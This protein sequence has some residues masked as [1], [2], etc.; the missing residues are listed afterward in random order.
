VLLAVCIEEPH[1]EKLYGHPFPGDECNIEYWNGGYP[2]LYFRGPFLLFLRNAPEQG[3][4]FILRLVNFATRCSVEAE[5]NWLE[6]QG[7]RGKK[8]DGTIFII[9]GQ[10]RKWLG[11]HRTFQWH[12]SWPH[13][14]HI[15]TC[16]LMALEKWLYEQIDQEIDIQPYLSRILA[17]SESMAFAGILLDIGKKNPGLF[18]GVLKPLLSVWEL[19]DLDSQIVVQKGTYEPGLLAWG[20]Q[21]GSLIDLAKEWYGLPHRT[22]FFQRL[23][24]RIM[25]STENFRPFFAELRADWNKQLDEEGQPNDLRLLIERFNP[26]NYTLTPA[27]NGVSQAEF[28]WPEEI[29]RENEPSLRHSQEQMQLMNLPWQ[30]RDIL[31][32]DIPLSPKQIPYLWEKLQ[33]LDNSPPTV[34]EESGYQILSI[35]DVMCGGIAVLLTFHRE[36]LI[37]EPGRMAWCRRKLEDVTR[38]PPKWLRFDSEDSIGRRHWDAFIAECGVI[39]LA[40]NS[41]DHFAR[42]LVATGVA[43]FHY[44]TTTLTMS[45]ASRYRDKLGDDFDRLQ[46]LAVQW[47]ALN[48]LKNAKHHLTDTDKLDWNKKYNELLKSFVDSSLSTKRPSLQEINATTLAEVEKLRIQEFPELGTGARDSHKKYKGSREVLHSNR[49]GLDLAIITHAFAWIAIKSATSPAERLKWLALIKELLD[50]SLASVPVIE[51]PAHQKIDS[52]PNDFDNWI[53]EQIAGAI[54]CMTSAENPD[55]LWKPI[56][57]LGTPAHYWVERFLSRWFTRG[58]FVVNSQE[59]FLDLWIEMIRYALNHPLWN[60]EKNRSHD[61]D[62]I[63]CELPGLETGFSIIGDNEKFTSV[64]ERMADVYA[65]AAERWFVMPRV[66][67]NFARFVSQH[68]TRQLLLPGIYW[69]ADATRSFREYHWRENGL[70]G[71]LTEFLRVCW[72]NQE[73]KISS[74]PELQRYSYH[75]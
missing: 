31:D 59:S 71:S 6:R 23:A 38:N 29:E 37:S 17:E 5:I 2:P 73:Q 60:P 26:D 18:S 8:N 32:K 36:W 22:I 9:E 12:N 51:D 1:R 68:A 72:E 27:K 74:D 57:G 62:N 30:C 53:Y 21:Q 34:P 52:F 25:L 45:R 33:E 7:N 70:K 75:C 20:L 46:N 35:E 14:A 49:P 64:I 69:L 40:E 65:M 10:P 56:L 44:E 28:H 11:D 4:S 13:N 58:I 61:L 19:Y 24:I 3:L 15:V 54:P 66:V 48:G 50:L 16:A 41:N 67:R 55:S 39:L 63:V 43:A 47:A 42:Y